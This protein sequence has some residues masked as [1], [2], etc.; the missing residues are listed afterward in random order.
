MDMASMVNPTGCRLGA[1]NGQQSVLENSQCKSAL[2]HYGFQAKV[3][4][5]SSIVL[6]STRELNSIVSTCCEQDE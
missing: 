1:D 6:A 4:N 5:H 2:N 3:V